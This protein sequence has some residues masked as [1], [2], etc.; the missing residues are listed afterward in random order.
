MAPTS[1]IAPA[2]RLVAP[3]AP[4]SDAV[5]GPGKGGG[6]PDVLADG[7]GAYLRRSIGTLLFEE[8]LNILMLVRAPRG[9][10][11]S[12]R[13]ARRRARQPPPARRRAPASPPAAQ[14]TPFA[15]MARRLGVGEGLTFILALVAIAP[16]AERLSFVT[17]QLALY[18]NETLGGLLNATFGNVTELI[19]SVFAL[20]AG[21]YHIVQV[22]L[23]GSV[24]SNLLLV[25]GM[26]LFFG[27]LKF[28]SQT[29]NR[30]A[31][32]MNSSLLLLA[33]MGVL[34]PT[35]L[36]LAGDALRDDSAL[37]LSRVMSVLL[38]LVY[39]AFLVFQLGTHRH[40]FDGQDDDEADEE[41]VLGFWG[42]IFWLGAITAVIAV[43]SE[44]MVDAIEGAAASWGVPDI[45]IGVI[46]IPI[47]G[48]AAEHA[49][50]VIFALKNKMDLALGI[51]VGS[52]TQASARRACA[53]R[54]GFDLSRC[55][56]VEKVVRSA[57][58]PWPHLT[59]AAPRAAAPPR[60][61]PP[62]SAVRR[63]R[64]RS[65]RRW[66]FS[67]GPWTGRSACSSRCTRPRRSS[68]PSCSSARLRRRAA[69]TG[70]RGWCWSLL[71]C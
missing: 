26:A 30:N 27:G 31:A 18:T 24:L 44:V 71:T 60:A 57:V 36:A 43:L 63:L 29:F 54:R 51:A 6:H 11:G 25:L 46:V 68:P 38:L 53:G 69:P 50:A 34:F 56:R 45:F 5:A 67:A 14:A 7:W 65:S 17:E 48:N 22:N 4:R 64:C 58:L 28:E 55:L 10:R 3:E 66:C 62:R 32:S 41:H 2:S 12:P 16:F 49:A 39:G 9:R 1:K 20:R 37:L 15:L 33:T 19:V 8:K 13:P 52:A 61:A 40:L 47:V 42:A 23:L 59:V 70:C 21:M 35:S